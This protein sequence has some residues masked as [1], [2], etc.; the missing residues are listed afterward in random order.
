MEDEKKTY[1]MISGIRLANIVVM[2]N[3]QKIYE[4]STENLP[5]EYKKLKYYDIKINSNIIT[6]YITE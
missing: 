1:L 2:Y 4:G 3:N 6:L 5:V